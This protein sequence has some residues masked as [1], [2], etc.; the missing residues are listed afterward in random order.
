[1]IKLLFDA[2]LFTPYKAQNIYVKF[3]SLCN[4][5]V[6]NHC[7]P[8]IRGLSVKRESTFGDPTIAVGRVIGFVFMPGSKWAFTFS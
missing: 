5:F 8:D 3:L 7:L 2:V 6:A 4:L 1:M